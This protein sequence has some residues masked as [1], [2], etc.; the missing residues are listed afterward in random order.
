LDRWFDGEVN[1]LDL[2]VTA[3][4]DGAGLAVRIFEERNAILSGKRN[5]EK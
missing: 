3:R 1:L 5:P 4:D 2:D